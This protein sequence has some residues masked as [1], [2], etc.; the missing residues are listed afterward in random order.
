MRKLCLKCALH[1]TGL[2]SSFLLSHHVEGQLFIQK[3]GQQPCSPFS[4][5]WE[6][7]NPSGPQ[8][9]GREDKEAGGRRMGRKEGRGAGSSDGSR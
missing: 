7:V 6:Q 1:V 3:W 2:S 9:H 5:L 4:L 8:Y